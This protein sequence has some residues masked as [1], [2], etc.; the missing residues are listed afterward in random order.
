MTVIGAG[1]WVTT[2]VT[3]GGQV[4]VEE[5]LVVEV[6]V[7]V[8]VVCTLSALRPA[9]TKPG[10]GKASRPLCKRSGAKGPGLQFCTSDLQ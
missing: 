3:G 6:V 7:E 5:L 4:D 8:E 2:T 9:C 10:H 1:V